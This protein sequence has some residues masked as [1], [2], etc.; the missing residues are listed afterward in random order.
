MCIA[1]GEKKSLP[2]FDENEYVKASGFGALTLSQL[3]EN[4]SAVRA[5]TLALF[6]I[7]PAGA[8][9]T[10]GTANDTAVTVRALPY[11]ILGHERHHLN[12]L[13]ERYGV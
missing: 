3:A 9:M 7:L 11:I 4:L 5:A 6:R 8:W 2:G 10:Q 1:R 12:V 13:K